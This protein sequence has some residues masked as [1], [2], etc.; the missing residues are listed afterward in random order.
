VL[1]LKKTHNYYHHVQGQIFVWNFDHLD[2][3]VYFGDNIPLY[4]ERIKKDKKWQSNN[5]PKLEYFYKKAY[6]PEMLT[7]RVKR[8]SILYKHGGWKPYDQANSRQN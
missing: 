8:K 4:V 3:V 7:Q 1:E 6:F 2:F 5:L